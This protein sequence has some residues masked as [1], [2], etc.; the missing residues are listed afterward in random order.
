MIIRSWP[1][2]LNDER[3]LWIIVRASLQRAAAKFR[4]WPLDRALYS[5]NRRMP[6]CASIPTRNMAILFMVSL[7]PTGGPEIWFGNQVFTSISSRFPSTLDE[8]GC[9]QETQSF[10]QATLLLQKLS[11][12]REH[13]V[14]TRA[15]ILGR[16]LDDFSYFLEERK[17]P[18]MGQPRCV[19]SPPMR[20]HPRPRILESFIVLHRHIPVAAF[21]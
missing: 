14:Q 9:P 8:D 20:T 2:F 1:Q 13:G 17:L 10:P 15:Q 3:A 16:G 19:L 7:Q 6:L 5:Q 11:L 12:L 21:S 4:H 18:L